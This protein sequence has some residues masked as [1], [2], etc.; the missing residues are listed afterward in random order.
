MTVLTRRPSEVLPL[1]AVLERFFNDPFLG[2]EIPA[3]A[4]LEEGTLPLD[5]SEDEKDIIVRASL[6]GFS[7]DNLEIEVHDGVLS[8]KAS[9]NQEKEES[10]EKFFRKERRTSSVSRRIALPSAVQE[11]SGRAEFTDGVLTLRLPKIAK[12]QPKRIK[13][14]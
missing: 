2:N 9:A 14:G 11:T 6:P 13:I 3:I 1:A 12:E 7:K 5:V 8:I 4:R 10:G